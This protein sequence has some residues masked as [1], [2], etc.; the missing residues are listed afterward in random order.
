EG[1]IEGIARA[2]R[3]RRELRQIQP[4]KVSGSG[5]GEDSYVGCQ[6]LYRRSFCGR[7][8]RGRRTGS[9]D[10]SVKIVSAAPKDVERIRIGHTARPGK[11]DGHLLLQAGNDRVAGKYFRASHCEVGAAGQKG[12][13][14]RFPENAGKDLVPQTSGCPGGY[15][16]GAIREPA[17]G[18]KG[19]GRSGAPGTDESIAVVRK[20]IAEY[21][22]LGK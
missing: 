15:R 13:G 1:C 14:H 11:S 8:T 9:F 17:C 7:D 20:A 5:S 4:Q 16:I 19:R 22:E 3:G 6:G 18:V 2:A 12:S 21:D 10:G